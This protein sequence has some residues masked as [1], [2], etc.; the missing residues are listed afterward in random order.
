LWFLFDEGRFERELF[1]EA[2]DLHT[3]ALF[4]VY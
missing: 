2:A 1:R 3:L 4:E